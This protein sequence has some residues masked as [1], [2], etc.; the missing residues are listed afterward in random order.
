MA[1]TRWGG[2]A[3]ERDLGPGEKGRMEQDVSHAE[4]TFSSMDGPRL[5]QTQ[6]LTLCGQTYGP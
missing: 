4:A 3:L 1:E 6:C 5:P 2:E